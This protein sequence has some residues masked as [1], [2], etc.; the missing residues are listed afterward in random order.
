MVAPNDY[1]RY[2]ETFQ[3]RMNGTQLPVGGRLNETE[4]RLTFYDLTRF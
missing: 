4:S 2:E 1:A 3:P